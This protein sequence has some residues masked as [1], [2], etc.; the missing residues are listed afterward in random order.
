MR[1]YW[2][3]FLFRIFFFLAMWKSRFSHANMWVC[4]SL[5]NGW[6]CTEQLT[7]LPYWPYFLI[8]YVSWCNEQLYELHNFNDILL[9]NCISCIIFAVHW[10][11]YHVHVF[12]RF[13]VERDASTYDR[14]HSSD[15]FWLV[16]MIWLYCHRQRHR[17]R[18][19]HRSQAD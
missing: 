1:L 15:T 17:H 14:L 12:I 19:P 4:S 2:L 8:S 16:T 7:I 11:I 5:H 13:F 9:E 18:R 3:C 6:T 10:L